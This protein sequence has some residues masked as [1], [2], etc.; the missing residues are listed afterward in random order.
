MLQLKEVERLTIAAARD[1]DVDMLAT[2]FALHP[3]VDSVT[4]GRRLAEATAA[5]D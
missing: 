2:A 5:R 3:L 1:H 4:V